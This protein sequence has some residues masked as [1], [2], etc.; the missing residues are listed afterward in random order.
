MLTIEPKESAPRSICSSIVPYDNTPNPLTPISGLL[1][2]LTFPI[3]NVAILKCKF[4]PNL[5]DLSNGVKITAK[6]KQ[7]CDGIVELLKST[8]DDTDKDTTEDIRKGT[9]DED[10][11]IYE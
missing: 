3:P 6:I 9:T 1:C 7:G 2:S 10:S 11:N 4:N 8:T 5:I